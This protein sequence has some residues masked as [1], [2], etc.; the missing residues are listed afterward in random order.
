MWDKE[1]N[2]HLFTVGALEEA[3]KL[4]TLVAD[5]NMV[6]A[7]LKDIPTLES[8]STKNWTFPDNIFCSANLE[9]KIVY[10][11]T[12]PRLRGPSTD[13][14]PILTALELPVA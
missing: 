3:S 10:C 4:L 12:D 5:S 14:V 9:E 1:Q 13:H 2:H 7:L 8:M 11:T 6:M